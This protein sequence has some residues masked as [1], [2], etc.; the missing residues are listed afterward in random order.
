[1]GLVAHGMGVFGIG[2]VVSR[3]SGVSIIGLVIEEC[4]V[5]G[6]NV[7]NVKNVKKC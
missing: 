5:A 4:S 7:R 1:M 3:D 2:V 6:K